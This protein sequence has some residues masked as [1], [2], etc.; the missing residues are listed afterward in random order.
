MFYIMAT[1]PDIQSKAQEEIDR[2]VGHERLPV[3]SDQDDLPYIKALTKELL[4]FR[5]PLPHGTSLCWFDIFVESLTSPST[6]LPHSATE[7]GIH[8]GYLIPKGA[9]ILPNVWLVS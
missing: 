6:A 3:M 4:R 9:T 7:E 1:R 5:P 8:D 2:V